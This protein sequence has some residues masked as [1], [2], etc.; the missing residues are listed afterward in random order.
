MTELYIEAGEDTPTVELFPEKDLFQ[1]SG[2]S[3]PENAQTFYGPVIA[4]LREYAQ[5]PNSATVFT[6]KL[7]Y[8]N[9]ASSKQITSILSTL[10]SMHERKKEVKV[11]WMIEDGDELM[12][13][14]G[15]EFCS[16]FS[17]PIE[18]TP[19]TKSQ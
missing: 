10:N 11:L 2:N 8:F 7:N 19:F 17:L 6:F 5:N 9:S 12:A 13:E 18:I 4:W 3:L 16:M 15:E 1:I 14:E